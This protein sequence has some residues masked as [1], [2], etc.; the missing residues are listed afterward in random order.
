MSKIYKLNFRQEYNIHLRRLQL[1]PF[2]L[3][4]PKLATVSK[5]FLEMIKTIFPTFKESFFF[6][7]KRE[8]MSILDFILIALQNGI[9]ISLK[10]GCSAYMGFTI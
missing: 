2:A 3:P 1:L 6:F 4:L 8:I 7:L 10:L 5:G 9:H